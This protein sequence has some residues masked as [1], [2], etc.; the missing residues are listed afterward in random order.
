[1]PVAHFAAVETPRTPF[2]TAAAAAVV[3]PKTLVETPN[4]LTT[5]LAPKLAT[6]GAAAPAATTIVATPANT[7][8]VMEA[9]LI[10]ASSGPTF[11]DQ[12]SLVLFEIDK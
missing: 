5:P 1:M 3:A 9:M 2:D 7:V 8:D 10:A 12:T 11:T 6:T 4:T